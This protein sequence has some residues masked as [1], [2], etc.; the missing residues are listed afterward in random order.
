MATIGLLAIGVKAS[1]P[2][3]VKPKRPGQFWAEEHLNAFIS[4]QRLK[5][6]AMP[7]YQQFQ[8]EDV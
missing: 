8:F 1:I 4:H 3:R 5:W 6:S 7:A 2:S